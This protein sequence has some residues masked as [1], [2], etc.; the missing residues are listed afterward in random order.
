MERIKQKLRFYIVL[1]TMSF[2]F[3]ITLYARRFAYSKI[4][5]RVIFA[6]LLLTVFILLTL[7][8]L[9]YRRYRF[10]LLIIENKI[11]D[12]QAV[13]ENSFTDNSN[14]FIISCFGILLGTKIIRFNVEGIQLK[15]IEISGKAISITYE[16]D[17][18]VKNIRLLHDTIEKSK[19]K[20][21]AEKFQFETGI[22]PLIL[23]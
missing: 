23:D 8:L 3:L 14:E 5:T 6:L 16:K 15:E 18:E 19:I 11:F 2:A 1:I 12:I 10:A 21:I 20:E 9:E 17:K 7:F 4:D 22:N 13:K